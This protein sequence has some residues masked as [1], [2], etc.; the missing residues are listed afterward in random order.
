[1]NHKVF[2]G[3]ST[4]RPLGLSKV[5]QQNPEIARF[6][7]L[8]EKAKGRSCYYLLLSDGEPQRHTQEKQKGT[9]TQEILMRCKENLHYQ[10]GHMLE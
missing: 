6:V 4:A 10:H 2:S 8:R 7:Q 3:K 1:M 9:G 5:L